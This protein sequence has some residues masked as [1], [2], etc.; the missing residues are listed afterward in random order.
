MKRHFT[1]LSCIAALA[2][3]VEP[4]GAQRHPADACE[5]PQLSGEWR[6]ACL[7]VAQAAESAQPQLGIL[8]AGGNPTLGTA[9]P[10]G[11][12]LGIL[13]RVSATARLNLVL[14]R[15]P[16]LLVEGGTGGRISQS[17]A[18]PAPALGGNVS[19][20]VWPGA[21]LLPGIGGIG[22]IDLLGSAT[23]LPFR[24]LGVPGFDEESPDLALG[25]GARV[26]IVRESFVAPGI[27][28]SVM[29]R[30]LGRVTFGNVCRGSEVPDPTLG[31]DFHRCV[32]TLEGGG[33]RGDDGEFAFDLTGWSTR[34]AASKR[35]L[36]LGLTVGLGHDRF[37]SDLAVGVRGPEST[38]SVGT[39]FFRAPDLRVTESRNSAF[40]NV[41]Y[42]L[43]LAT[44]ALE[45]GVMQGGDAVAGFP[46]DRSDFDPRRGTA[47]GS[48]G[49]RIAF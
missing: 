40:V 49:A 29:R 48:L 33:E 26:G 39:P 36:G 5:H 45:G 22:S 35:L 6:D 13:P 7:A 41:S 34:L 31:P 11:L 12:R 20:G 47:F 15:L 1:V 28:V 14:V 23:Y 43:L 17:L 27:S 4:A 16:D 44:I 46:L 25:F 19:L 42:T 30:S 32:E 24:L 10:G 38:A 21:S 8:I 3:A 37:R 18:V 9:S 2:A